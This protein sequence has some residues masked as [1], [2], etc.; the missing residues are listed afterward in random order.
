MAIK[1]LDLIHN[2]LE[3]KVTVILKDRR[4]YKGTLKGYDEYTNLTLANADE[5]VEN[6]KKRSMN[7]VIIRGTNILFIETE[8]P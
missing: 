3:K 5:I 7:T 1:P 6:E 2:A 8:K 4:I